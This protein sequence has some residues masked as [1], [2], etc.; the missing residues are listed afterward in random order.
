[1]QRFAGDIA[2]IVD[3]E[4]NLERMLLNLDKTLKQNHTIIINKA[5]TMIL[6]SSRHQSNTNII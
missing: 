1:M 6:V 3:S 5:T 4:E 2:M